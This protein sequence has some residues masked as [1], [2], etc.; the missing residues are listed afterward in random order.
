MKNRHDTIQTTFAA[1]ATSFFSFSVTNHVL[2][3]RAKISSLCVIKFSACTSACTC[4]PL[5]NN[6]NDHDCKILVIGSRKSSATSDPHNANA[7]K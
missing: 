2:L 3:G 5:L 4:S 1:F 7:G 6:K